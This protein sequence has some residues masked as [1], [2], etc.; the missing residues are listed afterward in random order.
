[1]KSCRVCQSPHLID[2][3]RMYERGYTGKDIWKESRKRGEVI[4]YKSFTRHF[5]VCWKTKKTYLMKESTDYAKEVVARKFIEQMKI[6]E[7]IGNSLVLLKKHLESLEKEMKAGSV[8]WKDLVASLGEIRMILK[9]LWD[10]SKQI[11]VKPAISIDDVRDKLRTALRDIPY[12]YVM[13]I[14][15]ALE[16]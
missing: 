3:T 5:R 1:M 8:D 14:E 10:I 12:E 4:P 7:E 6:I 13:K 2:Y 15:K 9:F 11:E 16:L